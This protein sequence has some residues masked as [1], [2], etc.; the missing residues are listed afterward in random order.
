[1]AQETLTRTW[2]GLDIPPAGTY[3][4]DPAHTTIEVIARHMMVS[5]VRGRFDEFSGHVVIGDDPTSSSVELDIQAASISTSDE[6]RDGHLRSADFLDVET[7]PSIKVQG[8]S[9]QQV[10]GEDF[11]I[12]VD[13]TIR[14][15]TKPVEV[16]FTLGGVTKDPWGMTRVFFS[17]E[18][19]IDREAFGVTWNQA[20]ETGGVMVGKELKAEVELQ[21]V[22]RE[23]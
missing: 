5:K 10:K 14:D 8:S 20:L 6:Q 11:K 3:D 13:L 15:V 23:E 19:S 16:D 22:L 9:P 12:T 2:Q 17:G 7:Y 18:F 1:M 4:V 21:A